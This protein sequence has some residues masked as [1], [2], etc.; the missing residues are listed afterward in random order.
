MSL[1]DETE[2]KE[3]ILEYIK[4][5]VRSDRK[6]QKWKEEDKQLV[7]YTLSDKADG[8]FRWVVCQVDTLRRNFPASIRSALNDLSKTLDETYGRGLLGIDQEKQEFAQRLFQCVM[9]SIRLL[10]VEELAEILAFRF[11]ETGP[12]TY[13]AAWRPGDAEEA[14]MSACTSLIT[15]VQQ[16]KPCS[17][18]RQNRYAKRQCN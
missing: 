3:D 7:I 6:M 11:H 16:C 10:R 14:V 12:P 13:N 4:Y 15:I 1:H 17:A 18:A 9:V 8:M 2:Q 5:V